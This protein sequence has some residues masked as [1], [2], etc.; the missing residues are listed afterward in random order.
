MCCFVLL[1]NLKELLLSTDSAIFNN[2]SART[3]LLSR[4]FKASLSALKPTS[5][6]I[7]GFKP[8]TTAVTKVTFLGI[9]SRSLIFLMES[10]EPLI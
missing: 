3:I 9:E 2:S 6:A 10:P 7:L 8:T 1:L 5:C 4:L